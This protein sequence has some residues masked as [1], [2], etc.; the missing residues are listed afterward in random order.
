M[1][2]IGYKQ[3]F[4]FQLGRQTSVT[5]R[6]RGGSG[7]CDTLWQGEGGSKLAKK[8]LR[9]RWTA[10]DRSLK[11]KFIPL[12]NDVFRFQIGQPQIRRAN[13][14]EWRSFAFKLCFIS[15][16]K[17]DNGSHDSFEI[18]TLKYYNQIFAVFYLWR[19][20]SATRDKQS[21]FSL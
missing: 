13:G 3:I 14:N 8:A 15:Q 6:G 20:V 9:N 17:R 21:C 12:S 16:F 7:R 2:C 11:F 5:L 4:D 1:H 18:T 19:L 10:P